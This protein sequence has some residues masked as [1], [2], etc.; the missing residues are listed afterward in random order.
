[1]GKYDEA[2]KAGNRAVLK[3]GSKSPAVWVALL[4]AFNNTGD[5]KQAAAAMA[6]L[7]GHDKDLAKRIGPEPNDWR[8][9][10][11]KLTRKDLEF[12]LEAEPAPKPETPKPPKKPEK[13]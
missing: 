10:V 11:D 3:L 1:M 12:G 8:N 5:K 4:E 7:A 13:K 9:A 6:N 2:I